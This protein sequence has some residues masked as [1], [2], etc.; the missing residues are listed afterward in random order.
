MKQG[1]LRTRPL[2]I[3][4]ILVFIG[5]L[6]IIFNLESMISSLV[7]KILACYDKISA[8]YAVI[9]VLCGIFYFSL[10]I[11]SQK[12]RKP[13]IVSYFDPTINIFLTIFTYISMF[14]VS[15]FMLNGIFNQLRFQIHFIGLDS[16]SL[17]LLAVPMAYLLFF[18][19]YGMWS[20]GTTAFIE[21]ETPETII[22]K[23]INK[24]NTEFTDRLT[25]N[26]KHVEQ[27]EQKTK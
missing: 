25:T 4:L 21:R 3:F 14:H 15:I 12:E 11:R 18:S 26:K 20:I 22:S 6:I 2:C 8:L 9:S 13:L 19:I 10:V 23:E 7:R 24:S 1:K 27:K 5:A 16:T 17:C